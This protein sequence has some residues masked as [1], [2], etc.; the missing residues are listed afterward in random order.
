MMAPGIAVNETSAGICWLD[1]EKK[2]V[3]WIWFQYFFCHILKL[4]LLIEVAIVTLE[5]NFFHP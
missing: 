2:K 4:S 1:E 5:V 3:G